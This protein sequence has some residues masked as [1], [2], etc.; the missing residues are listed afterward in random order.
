MTINGKWILGPRCPQDI[1]LNKN[2]SM[3]T[4]ISFY[5]PDVYVYLPDSSLVKCT[6]GSCNSSSYNLSGYGTDETYYRRIVDVSK[7]GERKRNERK[8]NVSLQSRVCQYYSFGVN[9][10]M[11]TLVS[12]KTMYECYILNDFVR[13]ASED[14]RAALIGAMKP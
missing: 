5:I 6:K 13:N 12:W 3:L 4:P 2:K 11:N 8:R 10:V 1:V 14:S 9:I 7:R